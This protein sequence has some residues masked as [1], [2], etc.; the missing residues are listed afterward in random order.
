[1]TLCLSG[2]KIHSDKFLACI[3]LIANE[4][5]DRMYSGK[6]VGKLLNKLCRA[7][8]LWWDEICIFRHMVS[9]L[10]VSCAEPGARL[11]PCV[12]LPAQ[13]TLWFCDSILLLSGSAESFSLPDDAH[14]S[15][16]HRLSSMVKPARMH[17]MQRTK[18]YL[19]SG[20]HC[21]CH[22]CWTPIPL[23][24]ISRHVSVLS[25][26]SPLPCLP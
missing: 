5:P 23:Q 14:S 7:D 11:E 4:V 12:S 24:I 6:D 16:S 10:L 21:H 26:P 3:S 17:R 19:C 15:F 18:F 13:D 9:F 25:L 20:Q 1:M 22:L 2:W 8:I